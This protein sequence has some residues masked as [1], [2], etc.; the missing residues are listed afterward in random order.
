[1][2]EKFVITF[3]L[4]IL[5]SQ[6]RDQHNNHATKGEYCIHIY[7]NERNSDDGKTMQIFFKR[8]GNLVFQTVFA[9]H[10]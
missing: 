8:G 6:L 9:D 10:N 5:H 1:M 7:E 2:K 3:F 4:K